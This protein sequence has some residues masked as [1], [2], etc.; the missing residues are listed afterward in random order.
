M[1]RPEGAGKPGHGWQI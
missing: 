1:V